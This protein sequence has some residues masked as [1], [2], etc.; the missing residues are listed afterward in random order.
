MHYVDDKPQLLN[1][2][3]I[4][5]PPDGKCTRRVA[6]ALRW[7]IMVMDWNDDYFSFVIGCFGH[8]INTGDLSER[9][10]KALNGVYNRIR[11][12]FNLYQL[13]CQQQP[14]PEPDEPSDNNIVN[15]DFWRENQ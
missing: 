6:L 4:P 13:D 9:Q 12:D 14:E 10:L 3:E 11:S 8:L 1:H 7:M 15:L 2:L 5:T